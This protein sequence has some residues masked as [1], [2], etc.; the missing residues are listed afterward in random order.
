LPNTPQNAG[1]IKKTEI[2]HLPGLKFNGCNSDAI[3]FYD[4][5]VKN[6]SPPSVNIL[7][8][9]V[10]HKIFSKGFYTIVLKEKAN[11]LKMKVGNTIIVRIH[12]EA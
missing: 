7:N 9:D 8:K 1:R 6:L 4:T 12:R 3:L 2:T 11:V 10:H 5:T